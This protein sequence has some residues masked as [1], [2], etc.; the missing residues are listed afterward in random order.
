[1]TLATF[2]LTLAIAA[3]AAGP[4][5]VVT[6]LAPTAKLTVGDRFQVTY[7]V[8]S[9]HPSL[10]TGP[11]A[12]SLGPFVIVGEQRKTTRR[13]DLDET[14]YRMG[15]A[16]FEAG[17]QRLPALRFLVT[18]GSRS[19][20]LT[21]DT[22][23]V[24]I[25]SVL[26]GSMKDIHP[27]KP[28]ETFPN[29]LL[30]LIPAVALALALL[31]WLGLRLYQRLRRLAALEPPPLPPWEEALAALEGLPWRDWLAEGE[32][33]RFYYRLSE[34]LKRYLERRFEFDAVEQTTTELLASMRAQRLPM[35]DEIGRFYARC[36]LVKYAKTVPPV[37]EAERAIEQLRDFV[38]K[39]RP[40]P[41]APEPAAAPAQPAV[42]GGG[43]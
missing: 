6:R 3:P 16:C 42:A 31:A 35:R 2:L 41:E 25:A 5:H 30:W 20:T 4:D 23:G 27:L 26:P 33:K 29:L 11:I 12:D 40:A 24:T 10:I 9:A 1:M 43:S 28:A 34:I 22:V 13:G 8:T 21:A 37:D 32:F 17:H 15:F 14:A 19:D 18:A 7:V 38:V 39:T 36:D